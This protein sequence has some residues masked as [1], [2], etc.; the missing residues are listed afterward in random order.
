MSST[1][2]RTDE[3]EAVAY[4]FWRAPE[5]AE[6][7]GWRL[8]F[9]HGITGRANS[10]WP[11]GDGT[12]PLDEKI[13]RA[14]AWYRERGLATLFQL[15]GRAQTR[16]AR[17][18]ARRARLR[19]R[20]VPVSVEIASL[21]DVLARTSGRRGRLD[22][23][24]I[25]GSSCG[26]A[27]AALRTSSAARELLT[28]G[29][30]AFA[31]IG[32]E[33]VGRGVVTG[34]W[35]GITSMV[36][37]PG[38]APPGHARA[39]VHAL[40]RWASSTRCTHAM[41]QVESTNDAGADALRDR[42]LR[43]APRVPL[44]QAVV[45]A[46]EWV[47][48]LSPWPEEF[49]LGR[50]RALLDAL[51]NPQRAF[52]S[53]HVVGT[54]GKSTATRTIAALLRADGLHVGAYT[55]PHVSGWHERTR[56]QRRRVRARVAASAPPPNR[57]RNAVRDAHR[58]R[59][60]R[61]RGA[62]GRRRSRRSRARRPLDATNV[63]DAPVVLLT[64]VGL[65]TPTSSATRARRSRPRSSPSRRRRDRRA[66]RTTSG[67]ARA[68]ERAFVDRRQRRE[69]ADAFAG[70]PIDG[71]VDASRARPARATAARTRSA[72]AHTRREAV[73]WLL[74]RLP[75]AAPWTIVVSIL[76]D[77]DADAMLRALSRAG[78][79]SIATSSSNARA[80]DERSSRPAPSRT[81][82]RRDRGRSR[83]RPRPRATAAR[84]AGPR[85]GLAVPPCRPARL[86]L[87]RPVS[88]PGELLAV[89]VFALALLAGL[90]GVTFAAGYIIGRLIL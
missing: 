33:A 16:R 57:R 85:R 75:R 23:S 55:S 62:R 87:E 74:A 48:S 41:L 39:I 51:D 90:V 73:A 81:S 6:L 36:T 5:V 83:R 65:D 46:T 43:A 77:K 17:G 26:P 80:L 86:A 35:L 7:D 59:V 56:H 88:T 18:S 64:N 40:A 10:V 19:A 71:D 29:E 84:R 61:L 79:S 38:R 34:S 54:N 11:N 72:T 78:P 8:R 49:G 25:H 27:R 50:M 42:R 53:V 70:R 69:A 37:R 58:R 9:A 12:L 30:A 21:D 52:R 22:R 1:Q 63:L 60:R 15:D 14:E 4:E 28:A 31:S 44:P 76:R 66:C 24:T 3:L 47:A 20:G 13:D 89:F 68:G 82:T 67:G 45:T 2:F 32:S